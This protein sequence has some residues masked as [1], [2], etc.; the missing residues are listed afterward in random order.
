MISTRYYDLLKEVEKLEDEIRYFNSLKE[1]ELTEDTT[2][3]TT[4]GNYN[5]CLGTIILVKEVS[6]QRIKEG[7][8]VKQVIIY[9]LLYIAIAICLGLT[10][11]CLI[12][13]PI[14][15]LK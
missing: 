9:I 3:H 4:N 6:K 1:I 15:I 11:L 5:I 8:K 12:I 7:D 10:L 13:F 14:L 2:L